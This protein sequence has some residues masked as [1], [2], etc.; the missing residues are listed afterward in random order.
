M[1]LFRLLAITGC[2]LLLSLPL[3]AAERT[4]ARLVLSNDASR[5][6]DLVMAGIELRMPPKWHTYWR[7]GGDSGAPTKID[8][9]LPPGIS[10]GEILWPVP[11][12]YIAADLTTYVYHDVVLLL[13]PLKLASD[14][15]PGALTIKA[16]VSWLECEELCLPG[17][18]EVQT[19]LTIGAE[20]KLSQNASLIESWTTKLPAASNAIAAKSRW[21]KTAADDA[22]HLIIEWEAQAKPGVADFFPYGSEDY[23]VSGVTEPIPISHA[24]DFRFA[25]EADRQLNQAG[26]RP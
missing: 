9:Q 17:K 10:A 3:A 25:R 19:S 20:S 15:A 14:M 5:A 13:V 24:F 23:E 26:W 1:K 22:R 16:A 11:E 18:A 21:E 2:L 6:G 12:K 4:K 8:W 7:F